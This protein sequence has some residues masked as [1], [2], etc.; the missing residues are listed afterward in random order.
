MNGNNT[1]RGLTNQMFGVFIFLS[2]FPQLVNQIMPIFALQRVMYE[3]R[4]RPSKTYSWKAFLT[5]NIV[6]ELAWNSVS[7]I[8]FTE[9]CKT[10]S[11]AA[12]VSLRLRLLVLPYW[13]V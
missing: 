5:A 2:V 9:E 10:N 7:E 12:N 13:S 8:S 11:M 4:E 3:A 6:V 1:Q